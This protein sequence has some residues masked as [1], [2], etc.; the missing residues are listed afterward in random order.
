MKN[1][2]NLW[3]RLW[4]KCDDY[5]E[6]VIEV[7]SEAYLYNAI[8]AIA[9][10]QMHGGLIERRRVC[11]VACDGCGRLALRNYTRL[12]SNTKEDAC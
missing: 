8:P 3:Q 5:D 11:K 9:L 7:L 2:L 1:K 4:H 12:V 10:A 6:L